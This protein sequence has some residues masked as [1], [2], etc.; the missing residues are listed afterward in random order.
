MCF[1]RLYNNCIAYR[2]LWLL[3]YALMTGS[4]ERQI[5]RVYKNV[6]TN[7]RKS[8]KYEL[9][10]CYN[11]ELCLISILSLLKGQVGHFFKT[12]S[13]VVFMALIIVL[14]CPLPKDKI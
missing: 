11:I 4:K 8:N 1:S 5:K 9:V 3:E 7:G 10:N 14:A 12:L 2:K 6:T 13:V